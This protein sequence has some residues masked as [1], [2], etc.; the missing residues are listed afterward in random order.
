MEQFPGGR[1]RILQ[2]DLTALSP[3]LVPK[4]GRPLEGTLGDIG[5]HQR[6]PGDQ[7]RHSQQQLQDDL[8]HTTLGREAKAILSILSILTRVF[9]EAFPKKVNMG[10]DMG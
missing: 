6:D 1:G 10:A 7:H 3:S 2:G 5:E 8:H 4:A 9:R